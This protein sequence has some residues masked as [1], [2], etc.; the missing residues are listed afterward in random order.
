MNANARP[1]NFYDDDAQ[2]WKEK[3]SKAVQDRQEFK[4]KQYTKLELTPVTVNT[5]LQDPN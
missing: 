2:K 4:K 5:N 1:P 3:F